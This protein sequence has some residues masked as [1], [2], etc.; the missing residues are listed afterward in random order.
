M[1]QELVATVIPQVDQ[2]IRS[3][4]GV[5]AI[6]EAYTIDSQE[7]Y[8]YLAEDIVQWSTLRK[9]IE[10]RRLE[11]SRAQA[12][13]NRVAQRD[14]VEALAKLDPGI[15]AGRAKLLTYQQQERTKADKLKREAE[16]V[17]AA[18]RVRL[19]REAAASAEAAR[20]AQA[21]VAA[22]A[23]SGDAETIA[24]A[25]TA[26]HDAAAVAEDAHIEAEIAAVA[27]AHMPTV[28]APKAKGVSTRK[29]WKYEITDFKALAY[30]AVEASKA[31]N[32]FWLGFLMEND[33]TIGASARSME[34]KLVIPGVRVYAEDSL[35]VRRAG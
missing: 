5:L 3:A 9:K 23:V 13:A 10:D 4:G 8:E 33:K 27:P 6:V 11:I 20:S 14:H 7:M 22:A 31:G 12:E 17:A 28:L 30:A 16:A 18:E 35:S 1:S 29:I 34:A 26:A 19:D 24:A 2:D 25:E 21:A 15:A 32:D